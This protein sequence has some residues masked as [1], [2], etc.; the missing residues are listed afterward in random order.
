MDFSMKLESGAVSAIYCLV[1]LCY[2]LDPLGFCWNRELL[3]LIEVPVAL[4][5]I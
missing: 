2:P 5:L 3:T 4:G 1:L